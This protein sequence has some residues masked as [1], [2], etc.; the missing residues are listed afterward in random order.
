MCERNKIKKFGRGDDAV[1]KVVPTISLETL[2]RPARLSN[3]SESIVVGPV[4][5]L[6]GMLDEYNAA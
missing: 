5:N 2:V 3:M 4:H 6:C 1:Y